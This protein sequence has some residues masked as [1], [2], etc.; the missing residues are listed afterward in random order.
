[1]SIFRLWVTGDNYNSSNGSKNR[2]PLLFEVH[3]T[4][5]NPVRITIASL[6]N[7]QF[8]GMLLGLD[9]CPWFCPCNRFTSIRERRILVCCDV[10]ERIAAFCRFW[11]C[12]HGGGRLPTGMIWLMGLFH[13][14]NLKTICSNIW[15]WEYH[16]TLW[17]LWLRVLRLTHK[18]VFRCSY[19]W[20]K[21][22]KPMQV[23]TD[24]FRVGRE[25]TDSQKTDIS[26]YHSKVDD[27]NFLS[28][29]RSQFSTRVRS[30]RISPRRKRCP[31]YTRFAKL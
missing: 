18:H 10:R 24:R 30:S 3:I 13:F 22:A 6:Q 19:Q 9:R 23:W 27:I 28:G 16:E 26:T 8:P 17:K 4:H 31:S 11:R 12:W 1:M 29:I 14:E 7:W 20:D 25:R 2:K 5:S 21:T 15:F